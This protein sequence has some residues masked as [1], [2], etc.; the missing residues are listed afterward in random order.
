[1]WT[2]KSTIYPKN[3]NKANHVQDKW[4]LST[5]S[6]D[7]FKF[8]LFFENQNLEYVHVSYS[9]LIVCLCHVLL[10]VIPR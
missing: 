2:N 6:T 3:K 7:T 10:V 8:V 9:E 5:P 4:K 1:M